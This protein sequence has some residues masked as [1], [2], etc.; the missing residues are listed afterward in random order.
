MSTLT[1]RPAGELRKVALDAGRRLAEAPAEDIVAWAV[2]EFGRGLA[3]ACSMAEAVLPHLVSQALPDVDVL[4]L[5][6]GYHFDETL[7]TRDEVARRLRVTVVNIQPRRTVTEQD[8]EFGDRMHSWDPVRCCEM[9]KVVPLRQTLTRYEA[10]A[11]GVRR[12]DAETRRG[13]KVVEWDTT[14][15]VVKV[16]PLAAWSQADID[17]Y[18]AKHDVPSNPLLKQGYPSI[19]C[20]PCTKRVQVGD[21]VRAGRWEGFDKT[22]CGIHI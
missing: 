4:F 10:W 1:L 9:R 21:D 20:F 18:V 5:D 7:Q 13:T 22:E 11:T 3:V 6:T 17:A 19:G 8:E 16:N 15:A 14:N 2:E 12:G